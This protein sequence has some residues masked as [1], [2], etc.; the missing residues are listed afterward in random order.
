MSFGIM[1]GVFVSEI[2]I[3]QPEELNELIP[4]AKE[5]IEESKENIPFN[6][7]F[8]VKKW[9]QLYSNSSGIILK[10]TKNDKIIGA[11]GFLLYEDILSGILMSQEAFWFVTK[12]QRGCGLKLLDDYEDIC[13]RLGV[14]RIMMIHLKNLMPEKLKSI[15]ESRGYKEVETQYLKDLS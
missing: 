6:S 12:N 1:K 3:L 4:L 15:Y 8:F 2:S 7:E 11:L 10:C 14:K 5:F 13:K 9:I